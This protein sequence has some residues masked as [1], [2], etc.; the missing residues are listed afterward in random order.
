MVDL[1]KLRAK[2]KKRNSLKIPLFLF[3]K[4]SGS[5]FWAIRTG[6]SKAWFIRQTW[7]GNLFP[8]IA[9][10]DGHEEFQCIILAHFIVIPLED[11]FLLF[12]WRGAS[13]NFLPPRD[14]KSRLADK[15]EFLCLLPVHENFYLPKAF[16]TSDLN[17]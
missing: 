2:E 1:G 9:K 14:V 4:E 11:R 13:E 3:F 6:E 12:F 15:N 5:I 16:R 8:V 10:V 7:G 17:W